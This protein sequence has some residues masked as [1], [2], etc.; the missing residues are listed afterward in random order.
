MF[1][2]FLNVLLKDSAILHNFRGNADG[3]KVPTPIY[4]SMPQF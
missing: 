4:F 2:N 1:K 3:V